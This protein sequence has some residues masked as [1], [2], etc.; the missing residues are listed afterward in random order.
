M[1]KKK[2]IVLQHVEY[3]ELE[4]IEFF[5]PKTKFEFVKIKLFKNQKIPDKL[6]S[7]S[8]M[9]VLGGPMNTFM[10]KEYPWLK[11]EKK[12]IK[13]FVVELEKPF[14]GIC[15]GC[16]LLGEVIGTKIIKSTKSEIGIYKVNSLKRIVDDKV[17]GFLPK[18][19]KVFQWHSYE[20]EK[21]NNKEITILA[22]SENTKIQIFRYKKHAY[23][24]QFHL[25]IK[26]DTILKWC[27]IKLNKMILEENISEKSI[28][29]Y[30]K[31]V[32]NELKKISLLCKKFVK[33]LSKII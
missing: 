26:N 32:K 16:Q 24:M 29:E 10:E 31:K 30:T 12:S 27:N 5:F 2:I 21:N 18:S 23:G 1:S 7:F 4:N 22:S 33:K 14:L 17:Y 28:L 9:I 11:N 3:E 25:E 19:F 20:V 8:M 13:K 15:L 6:E